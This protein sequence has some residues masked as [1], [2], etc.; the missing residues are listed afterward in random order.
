MAAVGDV[1]GDLVAAG[2][3]VERLGVEGVGHGAILADLGPH[4]VGATAERH[5]TARVPARARQ[6]AATVRR[7][8]KGPEEG[9]PEEG[10]EGA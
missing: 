3:D 2:G 6:R 1:E 4:L 5:P 9:P 10:P 7:G 8:R